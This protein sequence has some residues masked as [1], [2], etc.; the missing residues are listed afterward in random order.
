MVPPRSTPRP[1]TRSPAMTRASC[2]LALDVTDAGQVAAAA[3]LATDVDAR[4][5]Q[6]RQPQRC[7]HRRR[8]LRRA[9]RP[10]ST[11]TSSGPSPSPGP[12]LPMLAA[13]GG[14]GGGHRPLRPVLDLRRRRLQRVEGRGL[15]GHQRAPL[16]ARPGRHHGHRRARRLHRHRH[17]GRHRRTEESRPATWPPQAL[18]GVEAGVAEVLADDVTRGVKAGLSGEPMAFPVG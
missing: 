9:S 1:A 17:G 5:Q 3:A 4:G 8:R 13:H 18:D 12:S 10:T 14:G 6:R 15:V 7:P 2:P 16:G 11:P